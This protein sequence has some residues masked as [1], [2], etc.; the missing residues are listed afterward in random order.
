MDSLKI[1]DRK[2]QVIE[3]SNLVQNSKLIQNKKKIENIQT[4]HVTIFKG[5]RNLDLYFNFI[6]F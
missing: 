3:D 1:M 6:S 4:I 2:L 5:V